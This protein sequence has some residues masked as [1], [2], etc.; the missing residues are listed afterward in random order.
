MNSS[1]GEKGR[2]GGK[3]GGREGELSF[4]TPGNKKTKE[5]VVGTPD[6][7]VIRYLWAPCDIAGD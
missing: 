5:E 6:G 7:N 1:V 2:M 4:M 3:N